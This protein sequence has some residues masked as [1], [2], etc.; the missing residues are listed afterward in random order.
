MMKV[1]RPECRFKPITI[2]LETREEANLIWHLLN[3]SVN[4]PLKD[5]AEE[6]GRESFTINYTVKTRMWVT[7]DKKYS[8]YK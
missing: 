8:P 5:Y 4:K 6:L 7:L 1:E 3:N 2:I